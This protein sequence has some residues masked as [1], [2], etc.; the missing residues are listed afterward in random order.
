MRPRARES[1]DGV[2][3]DIQDHIRR[4]TDENIARGLA[5]IR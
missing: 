1:L 2:D 4:E 3:D 5:S